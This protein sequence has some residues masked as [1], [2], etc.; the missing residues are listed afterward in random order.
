MAK[1]SGLSSSARAAIQRTRDA[2]AVIDAM[3]AQDELPPAR[4]SPQPRSYQIKAVRVLT[5]RLGVHDR[6]VAVGPTGC[7]KTQIAARLSAKRNRVLFVVH[8]YELADQAYNLR[9]AGLNLKRMA[10]RGKPIDVFG[11]NGCTADRCRTSG[12]GGGA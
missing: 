5:D 7:G 1:K 6:V 4:L 9:M 2:R 12:S 11:V 8:R 10:N 3:I